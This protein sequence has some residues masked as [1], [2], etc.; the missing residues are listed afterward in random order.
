MSIKKAVIPAAGLGTRLKPL[1]SITPKEMLPLARK[2]AVEYI[3][4]EL[5]S[6]GID[7]IIFV[8]SP[9]KPRIQ[10]YFGDSTCGGQV[11]VRYVVQETQKGLAD[12]ILQAEKAVGDEHFVVALGDS[13]IVSNQQISPLERL[14]ASYVENQAFAAITVEPVPLEDSPKYGM[15]KP[16]GAVVGNAFRITALVEKPRV[17]ESPSNYAIAG[18]YVF[19]PSIFDYIRRTS[20]GALGELQI[21]DSIRLGIEEGKSVWCAPLFEGERRYDI[22]NFATFCE[23]FVA[24]CML[25]KELAPLVCRVVDR[26]RGKLSMEK[27][28]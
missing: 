18:R 22:G 13:V 4:E 20:P 14:L 28:V 26:Q 23:A 16:A 17:E 21:T 7:D 1:T 9:L 19:S 5:H 24:M 27:Q 8:V 15:V 10:E 2:P 3:V 6:A 12:A 25:D 11:R